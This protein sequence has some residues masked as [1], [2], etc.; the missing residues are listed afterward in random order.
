MKIVLL[1]TVLA[2]CVEPPAET[3]TFVL[4]DV[5]TQ[6]SLTN[7]GASWDGDGAPDP[8]LYIGDAFGNPLTP[9]AYDAYVALFPG[10]IEVVV[11]DGEELRLDV[12][13]DDDAAPQWAFGC[14][15]DLR[16]RTLSCKSE[17]GMN[18][19]RATVSRD[20]R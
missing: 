20:D 18:T 7:H 14:R 9:I 4:T 17:D 15:F 11:V 3:T 6:I 19:L 16:A 2:A 1:I 5:V 10:P 13:D 8:D 12:W